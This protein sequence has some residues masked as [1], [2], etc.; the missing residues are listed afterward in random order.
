[1]G[2]RSFR[3]VNVWC[4]NVELTLNKEYNGN[5]QIFKKN[6]S[7]WLSDRNFPFISSCA[8]NQTLPDNAKGYGGEGGGGGH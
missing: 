1:M 7:Y 6:D 3:D 2:K 4:F 5:N 8:M